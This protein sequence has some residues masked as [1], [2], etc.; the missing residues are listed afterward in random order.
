M[1]NKEKFLDDVDNEA[2]LTER[3]RLAVTTWN[4]VAN[5][6]TQDKELAAKWEESRAHSIKYWQARTELSEL[7]KKKLE[8]K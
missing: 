8:M 7:C 1:S 3:N 5:P 4:E 6:F 2:Y